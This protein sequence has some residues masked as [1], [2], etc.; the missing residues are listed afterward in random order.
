MYCIWNDFK[1]P[2]L[3]TDLLGK[4][5]YLPRYN[6]RSYFEIEIDLTLILNVKSTKSENFNRKK[7]IFR[8]LTITLI[9]NH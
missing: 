5:N 1:I 3:K 2:A 4:L 8:F 6:K 7:F 9:S